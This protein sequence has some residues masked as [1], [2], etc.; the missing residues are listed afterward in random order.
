[1]FQ[2]KEPH[3]VHAGKESRL[4]PLTSICRMIHTIYTVFD[5]FA[6][7]LYTISQLPFSITYKCCN[8]WYLLCMP[9]KGL[10]DS[11]H[12]WSLQSAV[13]ILGSGLCVWTV[14]LYVS[15]IIKL[16]R[17]TKPFQYVLC[18]MIAYWLIAYTRSNLWSSDCYSSYL[19][20][21]KVWWHVFTVVQ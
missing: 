14:L 6:L 21:V 8:K 15:V 11:T 13:S 2:T 20:A 7:S 16:C 18:I 10:I 19:N 1:M 4:P 9:N 3:T 17:Y 5:L 12:F